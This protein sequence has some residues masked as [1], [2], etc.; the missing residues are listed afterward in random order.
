MVDHE[1]AVR[2]DRSVQSNE[3]Q[4][5]RAAPLPVIDQRYEIDAYLGA[6]GMGAVYKGRHVGLN[7]AVAVKILKDRIGTDEQDLKRF[8]QEARAVALLAHPNIVRVLDFGFTAA[9]DPFLAME[10]IE[11]TPLSHLITQPPTLT[12]PLAVELFKQICD[13]LQHAHDRGIV[14]RDIKPSNVIVKFS[15]QG[16]PQVKIVD[17]GVAKVMDAEQHLTDTGEILGSVLYMSPE[18]ARSIAVDGRTDIYS[19]GCLMYEV[20]TGQVP[21]RGEVAV[22]TLAKHLTAEPTP[23]ASVCSMRIPSKLEAVVMRSLEKEPG[24]RFQSA[25]Q[26][27]K[28]LDGA[29]GGLGSYGHVGRMRW[30]RWLSRHVRPQPLKFAGALLIAAVFVGAVALAVSKVVLPLNRPPALTIDLLAWAWPYPPAE[31]E[32]AQM[33]DVVRKIEWLISQ[34][35]LRLG[36]Y[37]PETIDATRRL[38]SYFMKYGQFREALPR[39]QSVYRSVSSPDNKSGPGPQSVPAADAAV[40]MGQC[41]E[42]LDD[43][44]DA[45]VCYM[46]AYYI[47]DQRTTLDAPDRAVSLSGAARSAYNSRH[48]ANALQ[49]CQKLLS[50]EGRS[51]RDSAYALSLLG[52]SYVKEA[53]KDSPLKRRSAMQSARKAYAGALDVWCSILPRSDDVIHNTNVCLARRADM[54]AQ[55]GDYAQALSGLKECLRSSAAQSDGAIANNATLRR[56][57]AIL[58]WH[59]GRWID[60]LRAS[61]STDY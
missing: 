44:Q 46:K 38:A 17:F 37:A 20:L 23:F 18:Q 24:E 6:G 50:D 29:A 56:N 57:L 42:R 2:A 58:L 9:G 8:E 32:P 26:L 11:G 31:P 27:R 34:R 51:R 14:H 19:L 7:Q 61:I 47:Y 16:D 55:V 13:G 12:W 52:D 28:A 3:R 1:R 25:S 60:S 30:R 21:F 33:M 45:Y 15:A 4:T 41:Y 10:Y 36:R 35:N 49:L 59:S 5:A 43:F 54:D 40:A 39:L 48:Y 22:Q 53:L